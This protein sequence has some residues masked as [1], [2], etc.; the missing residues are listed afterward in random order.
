MI[1]VLCLFPPITL[2]DNDPNSWENE[3]LA[4]IHSLNYRCSDMLKDFHNRNLRRLR[5]VTADGYVLVLRKNTQDHIL[6]SSIPAAQ[7]K[8]LLM[9]TFQDSIGLEK[10]IGDVWIRLREYGAYFNIMN[11]VELMILSELVQLS[12]LCTSEKASRRLG[13]GLVPKILHLT[14]NLM[15]RLIIHQELEDALSFNN[16]FEICVLDSKM[17]WLVLLHLLPMTK[18]MNVFL[19]NYRGLVSREHVNK[20]ISS[21][22]WSTIVF[23]TGIIL[24]NEHGTQDIP[25]MIEK[26][27]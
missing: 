4:F 15:E 8:A 27:P 11:S 13:S 20:N 7:T 1:G 23:G 5:V 22:Q 17:E 26:I 25:A 14:S 18:G 2:S 24:F 12:S 3:A 21:R 19:G 16:L 10:K 9:L 6:Y